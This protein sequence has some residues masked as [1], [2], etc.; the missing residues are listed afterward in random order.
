MVAIRPVLLAI[1]MLAVIPA[2]AAANSETRIIVKRDPGLSAAERRDIRADA[3]VTFLKPLPLPQTEVVT[4]PAGEAADA[5]REL[6]ADPGVVYAQP[7][8]ER[9]PTAADPILPFLWAFNNTGQ[10]VDDFG[11]GTPGADM[12]VFEAWNASTG[13][14][15]TVAVVDT[16]VDAHHP[17]L[18]GQ[19]FGGHDFI[20][21][22]DDDPTDEEGHGT[23][24]AGTIAAA[25]GN[26]EGVA[27]VAPD[28][29]VVPLRA[30]A[31]GSTDVETAAAF[32]WAGDH[33]IRVVNASF[34][35]ADPSQAEIDAITRHDKTLFVV[36]AGN[37]GD[38]IDV[39]D[40]ANAGDEPAFPCGYTLDNVLCVG[41]SDPDDGLADFSNT[42]ATSVDVFAPGVDIISTE[43]R[44]YFVSD[45]TSMAT[46]HV[47]GAAALLV[48]RNPALT[49]EEIKAALLEN[50]DARA[51]FAGKSTTGMRVNANS[52]LLTVADEPTAPAVLVSDIDEDTVPDA[53]DNCPG[54]ANTTQD[55]TLD[56][57]GIGD[58]CDNCPDQANPDQLDLPDA[59][60]IGDECDE[61]WDNDADLN[62]DDN[63]PVDSNADQADLDGDD[64]GN[65]C[66]RNRDGDTKNNDKDNCPDVANSAQTNTDGDAL[67]DACDPNIDND[68]RLNGSDNC[69]TVANSSQAD[70]D[71][72]GIGDACDSTPRG[73]DVDGD[74]K[75]ALDDAC[76][77]VYG[78]LANG[79]APVAPA[80][81][82]TDG[83]DRIDASDAC[84]TE[85]A[86]S[87]DGCP[88][89]QVASLSA[90]V[91]KRTATL[92]VAATRAGTL[93]ITVERKK[94]RRWVRVTRRTVSGTGKTLRVKRLKR[95]RYRV[96]VSISSG[97]GA[98]TSKS[99]SF[100]VR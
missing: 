61:D 28:S 93:R 62:A 45:G 57:D 32:E 34:A 66:D 5:V 33:G 80:P 23:H 97:A 81:P 60:G 43:Q 99:K 98:G 52:S 63:C 47:A 16:G 51:A 75:P 84:P 48:A 12:D 25:R 21:A 15:Q 4:A 100:R 38:D 30:L 59:D 56:T 85:Y 17:D 49:V 2:S 55:E 90:K 41:A 13:A 76:P 78:T 91:R 22:G 73:P 82:N 86:I 31:D 11:P 35:G 29:M 53:S 95:G 27:G 19:V 71:G 9:H 6:N 79:C 37:E 70:A 64:I 65:V 39:D 26:G 20:G 1:L 69:P 3:G 74:G 88:L 89:A 36:A 83:D 77:N 50:G 54:V 14:G 42:G 7:A 18:T 40:P 67:G 10:D 87:N 8:R 68:S 92:K 94:G 72:D 44:S 46:P 58:V 96:R 24:V